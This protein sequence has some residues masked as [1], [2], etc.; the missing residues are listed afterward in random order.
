MSSHITLMSWNMD[1]ISFLKT[2]PEKRSRLKALIT[3]Q[4]QDE[5][6]YQHRPDFVAVQEIVRYEE[7]GV[8]RELVEPPEGYCY[9]SSISIDTARQ[10]NP[11]K[12]QPIR[13]AG[14]WTAGDYLGQGNGLLWRKDIPHCSIWDRNGGKARCGEGLRQ[15]TV[16]I[17]TGLFIG[18][19]D[20]EPRLAVVS[21]FICEGHHLFFVNLHLTTLLKEREGFPERDCLGAEMRGRQLDIVLK[22]HR[23]PL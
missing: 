22:R 11:V 1:G 23:E 13:K 12:W 20:T 9:Q 15:E 8:V 4:L 19:R 16:R 6:I 5:C 10:N 18:T 14:Q 21:H 2:D 3:R 7:D 17:D